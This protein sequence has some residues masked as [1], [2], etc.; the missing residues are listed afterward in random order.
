MPKVTQKEA[1][2]RPITIELTTREEGRALFEIVDKVE[3][4]RCNENGDFIL[5][6]NAV[7][8]I[9]F[10]SNLDTEGGVKF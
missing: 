5:T 10:L 1:P 2:Y 3:S 4:Y 8:L 9:V 6:K 7:D